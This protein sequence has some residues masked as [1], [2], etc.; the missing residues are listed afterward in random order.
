MGLYYVRSRTVR[1][2][3]GSDK[4]MPVIRSSLAF[5]PESTIYQDIFENKLS[6]TFLFLFA[7]NAENIL[8]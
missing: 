1:T 5:L 2:N 7:H 3:E 8:F 4:S 6:Q